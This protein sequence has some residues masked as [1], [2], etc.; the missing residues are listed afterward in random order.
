MDCTVE[1]YITSH[2]F[3]TRTATLLLLQLLNG[4]THLTSL[5]IAHRDLKTDNLLLDTSKQGCP[6]LLICDFGCC[7]AEKR[8]GLQLPFWTEETDRGGNLGLM[9]PEVSIQGRIVCKHCLCDANM[10]T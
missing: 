1:E 7:L 9:A 3:N 8:L 2:S 5:G 4:I 6:R 10:P